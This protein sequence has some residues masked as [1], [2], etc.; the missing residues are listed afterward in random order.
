MNKAFFRDMLTKSV[1][2]HGNLCLGLV[3]GVRVAL[4][5]LNELKISHERAR[6]LIVFTE[7]D[8]CL[9]DAIQAV[10]GCSLG[11]RTL[12]FRDYGKFA[13]TFL[14]VSSERAVRISIRSDIPELTLNQNS[15]M[16]LESKI[17]Q[18]VEEYSKIED[19]SFLRIESVKVSMSEYDLPGRPK[20]KISCGSC[21]ERIFDNKGVSAE[22]RILCKACSG[23][24][25]YRFAGE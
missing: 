22:G 15:E 6:D 9:T 16:D 23:E 17:S 14:D 24:R 8:R 25:Y 7:I 19:N 20:S 3:L 12:K 18:A 10:T 11:R 5:G 13:A 1:K 21:G 4:A 2:F